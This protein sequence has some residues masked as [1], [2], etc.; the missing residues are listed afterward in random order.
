MVGGSRKGNR[1][2]RWDIVNFVLFFTDQQR[3]ESLSCYGHP[4]ARTP[5]Y[6]RLAARGTRFA[7]CHSPAALCSPAR[8]ALFTGLYPHISGHRTL[9]N[10][11]KPGEPNLFGYLKDAGYRTVAFGKNDLFTPEAA[12][13]C[14]DA[15]RK[16]EGTNWGPNPYA[17]DDD[18]YYSF[19]HDP[20]PGT[21]DETF[22]ARCVRAGTEFLESWRPGDRPFFL[23][24]PLVLPH[25]GYS[26]PEPFHHLFRA[27]DIPPLRPARDGPDVPLF[28]RQSRAYRRLDRLPEGFFRRINAVY[29]GMNAY[30]DLLLGRLMDALDASAAAGDTVLI[31]SSDHGDFAGDYG[32]VE[33]IH[34]A[35]YDVMTRVPLLVHAPGG[36]AGHVSE[37]P[38]ELLDV[39]ATVLDYAGVPPGHTH[40]SRSLRPQAEGAPGDPDRACFFEMGF[41]ENERHCLEGE[42]PADAALWDER[43]MYWPQVRQ[44]HDHP[45]GM[46]RTVSMRTATRR[47]TRRPADVDEMFDL[48]ADPRETE[49]LYQDPRRRDERDA[50]NERMLRWLITASDTVPWTRDARD[51]PP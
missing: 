9:W 7:Q 30:V 26:A 51:L 45:R 43:G 44:L 50:L 17:P 37:E 46:A 2:G 15:F 31:A 16:P 1:T 14:M 42:G 32:L 22:D 13:L 28:R 29:L 47:L 18:R 48:A 3:A 39:M 20:F 19:M 5:N 10:L 40:F 25:P 27:G 36:R 38:V 49:N 33:K 34:N 21:V 12:A 6:D 4:M 8:C 23:Y 41:N 24:L 35:A 11:L